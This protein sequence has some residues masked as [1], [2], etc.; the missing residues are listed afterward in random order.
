[1]TALMC[2]D[3]EDS[4]RIRMEIEECRSKNIA[5]LPPDINESRKHFTFL[6]GSE[7]RFGL[8]ALK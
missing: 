6:N 8:K 2:S 3:E 1:M 5:V 7:I 4:D